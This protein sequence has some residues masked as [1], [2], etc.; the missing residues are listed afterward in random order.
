MKC[1]EEES[2]NDPQVYNQEGNFGLSEDGPELPQIKEEQ[3]E[4]CTSQEIAQVIVK[5]ES[6][7]IF[8]WT[9]KERFRVLDN[10]WKHEEDLHCTGPHTHDIIKLEENGPVKREDSDSVTAPDEDGF[11]VHSSGLDSADSDDEADLSEEMYPYY[12]TDDDDYEEEEEE[13][14][15]TETAT[16]LDGGRRRLRS[17]RSWPSANK[18][19]RSRSEPLSVDAAAWKSEKDPDNL[20]HPLPHFLPTRKPGIQL[21]L[22]EY[23]TNP[24][25]SKL[26]KMYFNWAAVKTLCANTNKNAA[27]NIAAGKKF[28]WAELTEAELYRYIGLTLYM[29]ILKLPNIKDFWRASSIF[30]M[31]YPSKVMSRT[32]FLLIT[33]NIHMS[34]P[35]EDELND[36]KKG[37]DDY[38]CLHRIRPLY[39]SLRV[40]CKA[41]YH[42]QKNLSVDERMVPTKAK[43]ALKKN[44]KNK[45]KK[46]WIK[47]FVLSDNTGYTFDFKVYTRKSILATRRGLSF[48][49]VVSLINK[50]CLGS[51][52]HLYCDKFYT[53]PALFRHLH[54]LG[55][56]A[57]GTFRDTRI[58]TPKT[59]VNAMTKE[60]PRGTVRWI[61]EGALIFIK[62]MDT[63]ELSVCS[64]MH[65]AFSGN[66][67]KRMC[68]VG[69]K[70]RVVEVPVPS[71][72][73]D[74]N[75]F[76][77]EADLSDQLIG[78]YSSWRKS[79]AWYVMVLYHFIDIAV[80]NSYL[81][82]KEL[83]GRLEEQPVKHQ[84]FLEQLIAE[85][86]GVPLQ[87]VPER[88]QHI[89]VAIV[90]GASGHNKA[91]K[92]RRKCKLCRKC[93]PFMCEACRVALCV[94]VDRNCHKLYH[95]SFKDSEN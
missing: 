83:C 82:S 76:M 90:E 2:L 84:A 37:T 5:Q 8:V 70:R 3:E 53:S 61:R 40:A 94:I 95:S 62:W 43:T 44:I 50:N 15:E 88:Y 32:R 34:D 79:R 48:D 25:P 60:S 65:T 10:I 28:K 55:F 9:G 35:A 85:L 51:G 80:T 56:G 29:W 1:E 38:D 26:F 24:S 47:F 31:P 92:G 19:K 22:S 6:E 67:L 49:A 57:C 13:E 86:C 64:T 18:A 87:S 77:G 72:V 30:Y 63:R 45:Q 75:S 68:K 39:D 11:S 27:K 59:K 52:Y 41:V 66:T 46:R 74:Y 78:S 89:P 73:K 23:L 93:T 4:V 58:G 36:R 16:T 12:D 7:E 21:P 71:A 33:W 69:G 54:D 91:S 14:E 20:P 17:Q 42:P 81:L